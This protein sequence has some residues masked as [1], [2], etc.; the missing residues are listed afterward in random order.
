MN[1]EYVF[2]YSSTNLH[3]AR[4]YRAHDKGERTE[5]QGTYTNRAHTGPATHS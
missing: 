5:T 2:P 4:A 1:A 3:L